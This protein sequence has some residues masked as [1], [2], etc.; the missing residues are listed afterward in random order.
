M[1]AEG[2]SRYLSAAERVSVKKL[3]QLCQECLQDLRTIA[4]L[5]GKNP[6]QVIN[7]YE[8]IHSSILELYYTGNPEIDDKLK[9]R[10]ARR[11]ETCSVCSYDL[12]FLR[13]LEE[14]LRHSVSRRPGSRLS[15]FLGEAGSFLW[16]LVQKPAFAY[17]LA[18]IV[19]I[20]SVYLITRPAGQPLH[21][22]APFE[23]KSFEL[24][25]QMRSG[26]SIPEIY[27]Q[28][29]TAYIGLTLPFYHL[30]A[31][32]EY[33]FAIKNLAQ[34]STQPTDIYADFSTP[35]KIKLVVN[36]TPLID[37]IYA[38]TLSEISK[39]NRSDT[40]RV[41]YQFRIVTEK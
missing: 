21:K 11:L 6:S 12:Q 39:S 24:S 4:L 2:F 34:S 29:E 7:Q 38:L 28:G 16:A 23:I 10:I 5:S 30:S 27:R 31:E 22:V 41:S 18:L 14:E 35:R 3:S 9:A 19:I 36:T 1:L 13:E 25:E 15:G 8:E 26:G 40:S 20:P 32:N 37:G 33:Q 17:A